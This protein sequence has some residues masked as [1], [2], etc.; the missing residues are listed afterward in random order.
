MSIHEDEIPLST[1]GAA[2]IIADAC[3]DLASESVRVLAGAGTTSHVVR[4]GERHLARFPRTGAEPA[5]VRSVLEAEH[6]AMARF[7]AAAEIPAPEPLAIHDPS[8]GHQLPW[9]L[10]T[11]VEV[12][13]EGAGFTGTGR[14]GHLPDHDPW[15]ATCLRRSE[16]LLPV[17]EL[18]TLWERARVLPRED[19]DL[20]CHGDL[21]PPNLL[22]DE[23][24]GGPVL[25]GVIDTGGF[26]PADPAL[27]LVVAWHLFDAPAREA[28]RRRLR[29]PDLQWARGAAWALEQALGLVWYYEQTVPAMAELGRCTLERLLADPVLR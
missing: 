3:P 13:T 24:S 25:C 5:A 22:L 29:A 15:V 14:G 19:A 11:W 9:S 28:L 18:A 1:A 12:D 26:A 8:A 27:D 17:Q 16:G 4:I 6:R 7:A 23:R 21:I 20:M 2:R 10:Q